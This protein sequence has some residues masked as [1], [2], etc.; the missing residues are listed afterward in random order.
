MHDWH[1]R[2]DM[3]VQGP[4]QDQRKVLVVHVQYGDQW[5]EIPISLTAITEMAEAL[6]EKF[7]AVD[8]AID[9]M[10]EAELSLI[11]E[12]GITTITFPSD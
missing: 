7:A 2:F 1:I 12:D 6:D 8:A 9:F 11:T 10:D 3:Q 4:P 5:I